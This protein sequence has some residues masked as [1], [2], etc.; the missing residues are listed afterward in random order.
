MSILSSLFKPVVDV[1]GGALGFDGA[2]DSF[3]NALPDVGSLFGGGSDSSSGGLGNFLAA[4]GTAGIGAYSAGQNADAEREI[5][6]G[7][8]QFSADQA[9][10]NRQHEMA[11]LMAK[12]AQGSGGGSAAASANVRRQAYADAIQA[13]LQGSQNAH[14]ALSLFL[15]GVQ[16]PYMRTMGR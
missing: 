1:V 13:R 6:L 8:Q 16:N 4:L 7:N 2:G 15:Q 9:A 3:V 14:N 12:L 5:A 10:L 11:M